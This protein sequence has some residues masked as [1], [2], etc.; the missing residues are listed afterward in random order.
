LL[1]NEKIKQFFGTIG[2][3]IIFTLFLG[4]CT[5]GCIIQSGFDK[6]EKNKKQYEKQYENSSMIAAH[7]T[8]YHPYISKIDLRKIRVSSWNGKID[9]DYCDSINKIKGNY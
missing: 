3:I 4:G 6:K 8:A 1:K 9:C 5:N 7:M 2:G